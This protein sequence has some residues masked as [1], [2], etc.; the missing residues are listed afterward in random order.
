MDEVS[1]TLHQTKMGRS[2]HRNRSR[3]KRALSNRT[4]PSKTPYEVA[5]TFVQS[6]MPTIS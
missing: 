1:G 2:I 4:M 3:I 6:G 5:V